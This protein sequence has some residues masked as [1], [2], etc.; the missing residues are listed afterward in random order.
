[1]TMTAKVILVS[2]STSYIP[3]KNADMENIF[4]WAF[5]C[6]LDF[7]NT[8]GLTFLNPIMLKQLSYNIQL[9]LGAAIKSTQD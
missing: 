7:N 6:I 3:A 8:Q 5:P 4:L 9:T 1:M 2:F